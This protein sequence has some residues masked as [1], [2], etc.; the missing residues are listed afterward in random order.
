MNTSLRT[1]IPHVPRGETSRTSGKESRSST[2]CLA[3]RELMPGWCRIVG[4]LAR[5]LLQTFGE[6]QL[7]QCRSVSERD[8]AVRA[9][10]GES[11]GVQRRK[12]QLGREKIRGT[13]MSTC[14]PSRML[15]GI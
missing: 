12:Q 9:G 15:P 4:L 6:P 13:Y 1:N 5:C 7:A 8:P 11:L 3:E 10:K 2:R 14:P